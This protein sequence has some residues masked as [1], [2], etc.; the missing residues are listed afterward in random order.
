MYSGNSTYTQILDILKA[1]KCKNVNYF[2]RN[3]FT[4]WVWQA[5]L[6]SHGSHEVSPFSWVC[7]V[8]RLHAFEDHQLSGSVRPT[9]SWCCEQV[10]THM[11]RAEFRK[12]SYERGESA[13]EIDCLVR[14]ISLP[15]R[16]TLTTNGFLDAPLGWY[17]WIYVLFSKASGLICSLD[18][19][20]AW[21]D[22]HQ[23]SHFREIFW[24][25]WEGLHVWGLTRT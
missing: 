21:W 15:W 12:E 25:W 3:H 19:R 4:F 10:N 2:Y 6:P 24:S 20:W 14:P 11:A 23:K 16:S 9:E 8:A 17:L 1:G 13:E 5:H 18:R 7:T 22:A